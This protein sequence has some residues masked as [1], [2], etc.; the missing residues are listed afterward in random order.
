MTPDKKILRPNP[1]TIGAI[2][3]RTKDDFLLCVEL[4][5][6]QDEGL[7]KVQVQL[8]I[9]EGDDYHKP[10]WEE[11]SE[12]HLEGIAI[13]KRLGNVDVGAFAF[14]HEACS[15]V[16]LM[17]IMMEDWIAK[18]GDFHME[19]NDGDCEIDLRLLGGI[20]G[21]YTVPAGIARRT[22]KV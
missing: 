14:E 10:L 9:V 12:Q 6:D 22:L 21:T 15:V 4:V 19:W 16:R 11:T 20:A 18:H 13:S 17:A 7:D 3:G 1:V 5:P 2:L 8:K